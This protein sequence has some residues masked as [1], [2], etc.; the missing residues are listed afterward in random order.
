MVGALASMILSRPPRPTTSQAGRRRV[1]VVP[2]RQNS[3]A[4]V[5]VLPDATEGSIVVS[6]AVTLVKFHRNCAVADDTQS[7]LLP[8]PRGR[9]TQRQWRTLLCPLNSKTPAPDTSPM[10]RVLY[11]TRRLVLSSDPGCTCGTCFLAE[12]DSG[13]RVRFVVTAGHVLQDAAED[14]DHNVNAETKFEFAIHRAAPPASNSED[15]STQRPIP[16]GSNQVASL[17]NV[18]SITF[19]Y[20]DAIF[21]S[22]RG[23]CLAYDLAAVPLERCSL[24]GTPV[25]KLVDSTSMRSHVGACVGGGTDKEITVDDLDA[26]TPVV[27]FGYPYDVFDDRNFVPMIRSGVTATHPA[28]DFKLTPSGCISV[29]SFPGDSGGPVFVHGFVALPRLNC[30]PIHPVY[31][32]LGV[33]QGEPHGHSTENYDSNDPDDPAKKD[34]HVTQYTKAKFLFDWLNTLCCEP[35][36]Q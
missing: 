28:I 31:L 36:A 4:M 11:A 5:N 19:C 1:A 21:H 25:I 33:N 18:I 8:P 35:V 15:C 13:V 17:T 26:V 32:F 14:D 29:T 2:P 7:Y 3:G 20:K 34:L 9:L 23:E 12:N 24:L 16:V 30:Y 22:K 27:L 10:E 6:K